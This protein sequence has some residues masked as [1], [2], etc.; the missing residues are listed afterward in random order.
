M[1]GTLTLTTRDTILMFKSGGA[2]FYLTPSG[3]FFYLYGGDS[4]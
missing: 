3:G 1:T 2:P 4:I